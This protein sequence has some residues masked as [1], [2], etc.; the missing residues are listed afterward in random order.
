MV[1]VRR[2]EGPMTILDRARGTRRIRIDPA[3][4]A[5]DL[6][7]RLP[8][9]DQVD[10]GKARDAAESAISE[11]ADAIRQSIEDAGDNLRGMRADAEKSAGKAGD[12]VVDTI[13][14]DRRLDDIGKSVR[15]LAGR[16]EKEL[17]D[18]DKDRYVRAFE[19]GRIQTRTRYIA[20]GAAAGI[21]A[22]LLGV[23]LSDKERRDAATR[24]VNGLSKQVQGKVKFAQDRARGMAIERGLIKP[25]RDPVGVMDPVISGT[26]PWPAA[27]G[28][29]DE[30]L[31]DP[32]FGAHDALPEEL[33]G[34]G[35]RTDS[36]HL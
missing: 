6:A 21:A 23:V 7:K 16:V 1:P 8:D 24:K 26:P 13:A 12:K 15:S 30:P 9:L 29:S 3:A 31:H 4:F 10:L 17:P 28:L 5:D 25:D 32:A 35:D 33:V 18:T 27:E 19:R 36:T 2:M 11:A 22:G 34:A 14:V 20:V